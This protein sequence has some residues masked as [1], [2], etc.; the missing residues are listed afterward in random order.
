MQKHSFSHLDASAPNA[1][2]GGGTNIGG[3]AGGVVAAVVAV[4]VVIFAVVMLRNE[5]RS[6][7]NGMNNQM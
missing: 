5:S 7:Q 4:A 2:S 3:I 1:Q 6:R